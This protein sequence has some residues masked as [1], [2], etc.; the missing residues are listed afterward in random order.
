MAISVKYSEVV[1]IEG[2]SWDDCREQ[3]KNHFDLH[4]YQPPQ[5]PQVERPKAYAELGKLPLLKLLRDF[6]RWERDCLGYDG[7]VPGL[8]D[9]KKWIEEKFG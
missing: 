5:P 2:E 9:A 6:G 4:D 7:E 3:A 8:L 1:T